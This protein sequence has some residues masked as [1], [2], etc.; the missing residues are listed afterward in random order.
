MSL[1]SPFLCTISY[2]FFFLQ[3]FY[4]EFLNADGKIS[5]FASPIFFGN[6]SNNVWINFRDFWTI[7]IFHGWAISIYRKVVFKYKKADSVQIVFLHPFTQTWKSNAFSNVNLYGS[8]FIWSNKK[9]YIKKSSSLLFAA[10]C[11]LYTS[12]S[13]KIRRHNIFNLFPRKFVKKK[14]KLYFCDTIEFR[15]SIIIFTKLTFT[16]L[17]SYSLFIL[18]WAYNKYMLKCFPNYFTCRLNIILKTNHNV[19]SH[20]FYWLSAN[21]ELT[22]VRKNFYY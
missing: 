5:S 7:F 3:L 9:K 4:F 13:V 20:T 19:F 2:L 16:Q 10:C 14:D 17:L 22:I 1:F 11:A 6:K 15:K 21:S 8:S 18:T 12:F